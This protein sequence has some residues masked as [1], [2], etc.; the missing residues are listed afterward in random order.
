MSRAAHVTLDLSALDHNISTI[1]KY[2]PGCRLLAMV[3]AN[4]Y[5]HGIKHLAPAYSR[6]DALGVAFLEEASQ[7]RALGVRQPIVLMEGFFGADEL[8][9]IV[10]LQLEI[11]VHQIEQVE[12]L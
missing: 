7:L 6:L 3:K 1:K 9:A 12:V 2:A 10:D 8:K 4:A 11:V 5:G